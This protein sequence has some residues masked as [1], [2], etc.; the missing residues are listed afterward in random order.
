MKK[1]LPLYILLIFLIIVN[2]FF[3]FNYLGRPSF[4]GGDKPKNPTNFLTEQ[5]GFNSD[6]I[7]EVEIINK[8][9]HKKMLAVNS[10]IRRLKDELFG[11][12]SNKTVDNKVIDSLTTLIGLKQ[13]E[14]DKTAFYHFQSI[15]EICNAEQKEKFKQILKD[16]V[17]RGGGDRNNMPP[18]SEERNRPP[19]GGDHQGPPPPGR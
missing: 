16:A 7:K 11:N 15:K 8:K 14:L 13:K 2:G 10:E 19:L 17:H 9:Q 5:L 4:E 6:Q 3:L 1:N 12:L 18:Q